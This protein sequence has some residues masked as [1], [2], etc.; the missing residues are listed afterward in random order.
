MTY[1]TDGSSATVV[2]RSAK[3]IVPN[4]ADA[5]PTSEPTSESLGD[6][7]IGGIHATGHVSLPRF[8]QEPWGT[9]SQ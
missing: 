8:Q 2:R 5:A 1:N 6:Q 4:S 3:K 9:I 7:T